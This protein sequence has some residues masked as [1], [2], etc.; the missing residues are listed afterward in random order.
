MD[1]QI[2][3]A[4]G[5][6]P[7]LP[8]PPVIRPA[9]SEDVNSSEG[10][11]V[12]L[13]TIELGFQNFPSTPHTPWQTRSKLSHGRDNGRYIG[14]S[15]SLMPKEVEMSESTRIVGTDVLINVSS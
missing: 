4:G 10:G 15:D 6:S 5:E 7:S 13:F 1:P 8:H 3:Q 2:C 11:S 12:S 14:T 9:I